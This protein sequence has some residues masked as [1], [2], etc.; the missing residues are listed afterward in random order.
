MELVS[1][2]GLLAN[3]FLVIELTDK[4]VKSQGKF[5][6]NGIESEKNQFLWKNVKVTWFL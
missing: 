3:E 4:C 2:S 6:E 5:A 1:S